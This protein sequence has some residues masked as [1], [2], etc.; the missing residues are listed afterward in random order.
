MS[1]SVQ[2]GLVREL[3]MQTDYLACLQ[4]CIHVPFK[5]FERN[6]QKHFG[7]EQITLSSLGYRKIDI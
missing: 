2:M 3:N 4:L 7:F 1:T 6:I 5:H